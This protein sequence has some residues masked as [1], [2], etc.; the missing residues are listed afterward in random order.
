[1]IRPDEYICP[2]CGLVL[3]SLTSYHHHYY[4][5]HKRR[6][7]VDSIL[8]GSRRAMMALKAVRWEMESLFKEA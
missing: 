7:A 8:A 6:D 1:M 4:K 3:P 2:V 5:K